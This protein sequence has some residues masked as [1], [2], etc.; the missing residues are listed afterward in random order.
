MPEY[1]IKSQ[2]STNQPLPEGRL[3]KRFYRGLHFFLTHWKH[4]L[5]IVT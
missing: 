2:F 3:Q 5:L 1:V 4:T